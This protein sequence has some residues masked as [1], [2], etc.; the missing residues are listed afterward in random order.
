MRLI[1]TS[2]H[3][4]M[5]FLC[6]DVEYCGRKKATPFFHSTFNHVCLVFKLGHHFSLLESQISAAI[7]T[8][9]EQAKTHVVGKQ[10]KCTWHTKVLQVKRVGLGRLKMAP[11]PGQ[12]D[13]EKRTN[14][15]LGVQDLV[16]TF[17]ERGGKTVSE[18]GG[19]RG[20]EEKV[21][22]GRTWA[23]I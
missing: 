7:P 5:R 23:E 1:N 15:R 20:R 13:R 8:F 3:R 4:N 22:E 6:H 21:I 18:R 14:A 16:L 11:S 19:S 17:Y 2:P 9:S 10:V 12:R